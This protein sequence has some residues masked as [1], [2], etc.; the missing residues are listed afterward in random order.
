MIS[1]STNWIAVKDGDPRAVGLYNRH[2]SAR[3]GNI[4]RVRYGFSGQGE[5]LLLMT[6]DCTALFGWRKQKTS[7]DGQEGV[8][9]FVFRNEGE[10]LSSDLIK[11]AME[12]AFNKW[13]SQRLFTYIN[14]LKITHKRDPGRCFLKAGWQKC[15]IS[16]K[17]KLVIL[18]YKQAVLGE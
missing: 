4:D 8:N 17:N 12:W 5:S 10:I 1:T 11:D 16:K 7:D 14:P 18:E 15:G 9:C 13:G 3:K 2:Y 6:V